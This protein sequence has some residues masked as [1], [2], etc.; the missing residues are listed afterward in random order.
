MKTNRKL[1]KIPPQYKFK[2]NFL[3]IWSRI[4]Y[5]T[6]IRSHFHSQFHLPIMRKSTFCMTK[7]QSARM[8]TV[9]KD[10]KIVTEVRCKKSGIQKLIHNQEMKSYQPQI[11]ALTS[12][13]HLKNQGLMTES[14]LT[15]ARSQSIQLKDHRSSNY[16]RIIVG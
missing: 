4:R 7:Q 3:V 5:T 16:Q 15:L 11:S 13:N 10:R 6:L 8:S 2:T 12:S 1:S 14:N 9:V